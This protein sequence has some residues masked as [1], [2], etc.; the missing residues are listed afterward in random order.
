VQIRFFVSWSS[1]VFPKLFR[2]FK[3]IVS[4]DFVICF[5]VSFDR[6][7]I[8]THQE[9]VLLLF[10]SSFS[11]QIFR[12]S[13]LGVVSLHCEW[14]WALSLY[15][16]TVIAQYWESTTAFMQI[17]F[18]Q[19]NFEAGHCPTPGLFTTIRSSGLFIKISLHFS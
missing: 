5:L 9:R 12:F 18:W 10:K 15:A 2:L 11:C 13:C 17:L 7:D 6:S 1:S 14:S 16:A 8:S 3:G 4:W 19:K